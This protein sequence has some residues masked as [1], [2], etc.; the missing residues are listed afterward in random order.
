MT[1]LWPLLALKCLLKEQQSLTASFIVNTIVAYLDRK[2]LRL[3]VSRIETCLD[4][5]RYTHNPAY[6]VV[7]FILLPGLARGQIH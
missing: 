7:D 4:V 3:F 2:N 5:L 6:Y 1:Y